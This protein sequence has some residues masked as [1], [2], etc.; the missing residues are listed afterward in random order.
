[1]KALYK[2]T[3]SY[4]YVCFARTC[5]L[6]QHNLQSGTCA[7]AAKQGHYTLSLV[8]G[9]ILSNMYS[10]TH[11]TLQHKSIIFIVKI[12]INTNNKIICMI[13]I[14][15]PTLLMTLSRLSG[16]PGILYNISRDTRK[17]TVKPV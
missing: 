6:A 10:I 8:K 13:S 11:C 12:P 3:P 15:K 17:H 16:H 4:E 1:M 9:T 14:G 7:K 2:S 5:E